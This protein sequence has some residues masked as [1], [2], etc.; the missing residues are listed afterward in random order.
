MPLTAGFAGKLLLFFSALGVPAPAADLLRDQPAAEV[1]RL[2]EQVRLFRVLALVGVLN[3]AVGAW[4]YLRLAT[5]MFLREPLQPIE[6]PRPRPALAAVAVCALVTLLFG[7]WWQPLLD[8]SRAAADPRRSP[9]ADRPPLA[10][11]LAP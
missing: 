8:A 7:V 3:A 10:A 9:A 6:R 5:V 4:Y 11:R 2:L 1:A